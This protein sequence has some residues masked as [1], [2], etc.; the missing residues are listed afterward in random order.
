MGLIGFGLDLIEDMCL[1]AR[2]G[3]FMASFDLVHEC[4]FFS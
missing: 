2:I 1:I 4:Q 3:L